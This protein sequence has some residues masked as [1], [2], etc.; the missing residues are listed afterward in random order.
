MAVDQFLSYNR[1][2]GQKEQRTATQE[3]GSGQGGRIVALDNAGFLAAT[4]IDDT[5]FI[6]GT[7][8]TMPMGVAMAASTFVTVSGGL[9]YPADARSWAT[10]AVG[11]LQEGYALGAT[12]T[13]YK[14]GHLTLSLP[15]TAAATAD[16]LLRPVYLSASGVAT[17]TPA[18]EVGNIFQQVGHVTSVTPPSSITVAVNLFDW[19]EILDTPGAPP[20]VPSGQEFGF[21]LADTNPYSLGTFASPGTSLYA[22]RADHV[23]PKPIITWEMLEHVPTT[24]QPA[25][26]AH[27]HRF[28]HAT[29][30]PAHSSLWLGRL[31]LEPGGAMTLE[32][33][34]I[35][36]I[37]G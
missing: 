9:L 8:F 26:H 16:D 27:P 4:M 10:S 14:N 20:P 35:L 7:L 36:K 3:G 5:R 19:E 25:Q 31:E 29:T 1:E 18:W 6:G 34:A 13:V 30:I 22:S 33:G 17:L 21:L 12:A 2:T 23:H 11:F 37:G 32:P 28:A 15:E 24:F